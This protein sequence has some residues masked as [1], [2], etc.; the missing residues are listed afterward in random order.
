MEKLANKEMM[1]ATP[2]ITLTRREMTQLI[3]SRKLL[4]VWSTKL[5]GTRMRR[6][7][8]TGRPTGG[9]SGNP[10]YKQKG[11]WVMESQTNNGEWRT[12]VLRTVD[13]IKDLNDNQF[14][15]VR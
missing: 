2:T 12:I 14:Y 13:K 15:K 7:M 11:Q 5:D 10:R 9:R 8:K 1:F 4:R 6:V 3:K